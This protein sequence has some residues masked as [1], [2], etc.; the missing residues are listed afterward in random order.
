MVLVA[1]YFLSYADTHAVMDKLG[2]PDK[3]VDDMMLK[4]PINDWLAKAKRFHVVCNTIGDIYSR[5]KDAV[6]VLLITHIKAVRQGPSQNIDLLSERGRDKNVKQWLIQEGGAKE[7][8]LRWMSFRDGGELDLLSCG[9][10]PKRN[11]F[12]GRRPTYR[13]TPEQDMRWRESG[14]TIQEWDAEVSAKGEVVERNWMPP[15]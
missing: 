2:I 15:P 11:N 5:Y 4:F 1:G 6:G 13:L 3:G 7:D 12:G 9:T 8:R 14:K 10:R